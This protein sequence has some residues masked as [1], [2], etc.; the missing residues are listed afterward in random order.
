MLNN[1][2][3]EFM[4]DKIGSPVERTDAAEKTGGWAKY[5]DDYDFPGALHGK[6]YR[7]QKA[8]AEIKKINLPELPDGYHIIGRG[9]VPGLNAVSMIKQDMP[10]FADG[11]VNHIGEI[12]LL[13]AGPEK[14]GVLKIHSEIE[15]E[16]KELPPVFTTVEALKKGDLFADYHLKKGDPDTAFKNAV[17]IIEDRITTGHQE[18]IYMEPQ[19]LY[20]S[21][22]DGQVVMHGS[23]QCPYY[24]KHSVVEALGCDEDMVRVVQTTTGGAFGGKEDYPEIIGT[25]LAIAV[26]KI[27]KPVRLVLDRIEDISFT[28][29]RH[30]SEIVLKTAVDEENNITGMDIDIVIDG[31]AYETYSCIVLQRAVF[32]ST[33]VYDIPNVNVR[34]RACRTNNVPNGAFRGFG[35]PQALTAIETHMGHT[36]EEIGENP[37]EFKKKYFLKKGSATV[38]NGKIHED[39]L[40]EKMFNIIDKK[41]GYAEKSRQY[42]TVPGKGIGIS[43]YNHG[44]GFTGDGEQ[45]IIKA[46][47]YLDKKKNGNVEILVSNVEMGQGLRTNFPKIVSRI[48]EIPMENIIFKDPDTGFVPN[49]G[50]T[51]ASRSIMVVGFLLQEA[52]KKMKKRWNDEEEFRVEQH[53]RHPEEFT[54]NQETMQGDAYP[55]YGWGITVVEAEAD[56]DTYEITASRIWAVHEAGTAIDEKILNGQVQGGVMQGLGWGSLEKLQLKEGRFLQTTMADY[57]IPTAMDFPRINSE[58]VDNPYPY[59]PFGAKGAGELVFD[60]AGAAYLS[61]VESAFNIKISALPVTPEAI[62]EVMLK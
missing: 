10:A 1:T 8:R 14:S 29:K 20:G 44:C 58:F 11:H 40:L 26:N 28:C 60:G 15:I 32:S 19:S 16:Y 42:R 37:A 17:R 50:P 21:W 27:K 59:G 41:S 3:A 24:V 51:A 48:L 6:F 56:P 49:S 34:G 61:A 53:Y 9:D 54:W 12:I 46:V 25:P 33:G 18:H 30:P 22:K 23:M 5:L 62:M 52:A 13:I 2:G 4:S 43:F 31:G 45:T 38:T 39:V 35:A 47:V 57:I 7:S 55:A 36:A